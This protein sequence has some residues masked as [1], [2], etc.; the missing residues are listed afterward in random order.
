MKIG[1]LG[2]HSASFVKVSQRQ[3]STSSVVGNLVVSLEIIP[4]NSRGMV[5]LSSGKT[6]EWV[7]SVIFGAKC[8][9]HVIN[10]DTIASGLIRTQ[11]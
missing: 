6:I 4:C 8:F 10:N 7:V 2:S 1:S 9:W 11:E 3:F 5:M